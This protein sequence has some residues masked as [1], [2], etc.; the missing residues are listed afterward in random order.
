MRLAGVRGVA[1]DLARLVVPVA[2][3]GCGLE[4]V[5]LCTT[6]GA[7]LDGPPVRAEAGAPRWDRL[8]GEVLPIWAMAHYVGPVRELVVAWKDHGRV[9]LT[10]ALE[11]S[12]RHGMV[13]IAVELATLGPLVVVPVPSSAAARRRRGADLVGGLARCLV[14]AARTAD[15]EVTMS[16]A[17]GQRRGVKDQV[18]LGSRARSRNLVG[19]VRVR[20]GFSGAGRVPAGVRI[21]L[22][23][24]VVT[25]GATLAACARALEGVGACVVGAVVVAATPPPGS[26]LRGGSAWT[27][28]RPAGHERAYGPVRDDPWMNS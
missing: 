27:G 8:R 10:A 13:A 25:T 24:D 4:D 21:L 20:R 16:R 12:L 9:D 26:A 28:V 22:V 17:L 5:V 3:A 14:R 7:L 6:C 2:C 15:V 11:A 1:R 18:G 23:D 19:G